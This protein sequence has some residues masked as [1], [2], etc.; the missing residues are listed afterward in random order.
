LNEGVHIIV[1]R[2][3]VLVAVKNEEIYLNKCLE[4]L[5]NQNFPSEMY[6]IVIIDGMSTDRTFQIASDWQ[7]KYPSRISVV[8]NPSEW[9]AAGRNIGI[10]NEKGSNLIAYIDGHCI[11]DVDWMKNLYDVFMEKKDQHLAGVGSIIACPEDESELGKAIDLIYTTLL[12]AAGSSFKSLNAI[13]EV[14]TVPFVLY[15][16]SALEKVRFYDEEMKFGEDFSL[17]F[18]LRRAEMKLFVNPAAIVYYYKRKSIPDF[19]CQMYNYG[20]TKAILAKKYPDSITLHHYLPSAILIFN[21]SLA[22][23]GFILPSLWI[24]LLLLMISYFLIIISY[25]IYFTVTQRKINLLILVPIVYLTEHLGYSIG[26]LAGL[27]KI[28]WEK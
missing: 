27:P 6:R 26:F 19:F 23:M 18:K 17:N 14:N 15:Q 13:S 28:G 12:G 11:A 9:Q 7:S 20:V 22:T 8:K 10:K 25:G 2:I 5:I 1:D 4:S 24:F 16:K 21:A 3:S